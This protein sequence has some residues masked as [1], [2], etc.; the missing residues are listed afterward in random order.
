V[1]DEAKALSTALATIGKFT[2][3][4]K[5]GEDKRIFGRHAIAALGFV[6]SLHLRLASRARRF[7]AS[8][9]PRRIASRSRRTSLRL[10]RV[11]LRRSVSEQDVADAVF[12]QT[13]KVLEKKNISMPEI[14]L[15]GS[16]DISVKLHPQV[17]P[18]QVVRKRGQTLNSPPLRRSLPSSCSSW[19]RFERDF[20]YVYP[21]C[22][23]SCLPRLPTLVRVKL[24]SFFFTRQL[25]KDDSREMQPLRSA[26][27]RALATA[28]RGPDPQGV[29]ADGGF[30]AG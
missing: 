9:R 18:A 8:I 10:T 30:P 14:K 26:Q 19:Q 29:L 28:R 3:K 7:A 12:K 4:V 1:L 24:C 21:C 20:A 13:T 17:R 23:S 5:V 2:V 15:T 22:C 27:V 6:A 11:R 25:P 16:Y